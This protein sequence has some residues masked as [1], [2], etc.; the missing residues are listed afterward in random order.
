MREEERKTVSPRN[1]DSVP[2]LQRAHL[3]GP[4]VQ[5]LIEPCGQLCCLGFCRR[6]QMHHHLGSCRKSYFRLNDAPYRTPDASAYT[7]AP[8]AGFMRVRVRL[9]PTSQSVWYG[10]RV[11]GEVGL[12]EASGIA[13]SKESGDL[14]LEHRP[15]HLRQV[16]A[17]RHWTVVRKPETR[18]PF[19]HL[20]I[21]LSI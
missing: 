21:K 2:V 3:Y 7:T 13:V 11:L 20:Q 8:L 12:V 1:E 6:I 16:L 14:L 4:I 15:H 17:L 10:V 19:N 9:W 5:G 18:V